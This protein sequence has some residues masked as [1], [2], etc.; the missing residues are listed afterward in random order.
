M[1]RARDWAA[2]AAALAACFVLREAA[3][4]MLSEEE[5]RRLAV[6]RLAPRRATEWGAW[7]LVAVMAAI[8]EEI[9]YRGVGVAVLGYATGN[10][11]VAVF[12][13]AFAFAVAH[14]LQGVKSAV[15][16]FFFALVMHG[17]VQMTGTL[18]PAMAVHLTYDVIAAMSIAR[19][20]ERYDRDAEAAAVS[21]R[22]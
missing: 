15:V 16:I 11:L 18:V 8:A 14:A 7:W 5:R 4:R 17:L 22:T 2:A 1:A 20:A 9:A 6:Y 3:R 21:G 13:C 19:E 10:L 12:V